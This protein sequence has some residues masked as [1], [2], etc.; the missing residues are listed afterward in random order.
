MNVITS[1]ISA[2]NKGDN[3]V[4][5]PMGTDDNGM[6][7]WRI[8]SRDITLIVTT[9]PGYALVIIKESANAAT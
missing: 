5:V 8:D 7:M 4:I 2:G 6:R 3:P 1:F 9:K